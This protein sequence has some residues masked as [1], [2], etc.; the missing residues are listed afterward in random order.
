MSLALSE[1]Q[2]RSGEKLTL[3]VND[4]REVAITLEVGRNGRCF[5]TGPENGCQGVLEITAH[6]LR[7]ST[8]QERDRV[9]GKNR[10]N[11]HP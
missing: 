4:S 5:I 9:L 2:I 7:L 1:L 6:G 3:R 8:L 11:H 10:K